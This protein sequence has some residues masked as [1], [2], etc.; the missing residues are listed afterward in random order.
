MEPR[1]ILALLQTRW[2]WLFL[3]LA[4]AVFLIIRALLYAS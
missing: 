4:A 1:S 2:G 3:I